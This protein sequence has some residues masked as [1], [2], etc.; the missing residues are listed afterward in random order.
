MTPNI[1]GIK[2]LPI[3]EAYKFGIE[4]N[5]KDEISIIQNMEINWGPDYRSTIRRGF[6]VALFIYK[7]IFEAFKEL[8][9][10][11][12]RT[13]SGEKRISKYL[14]IKKLVDI[15]TSASPEAIEQ[16]AK[17][18]PK[19]LLFEALGYLPNLLKK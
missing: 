16:A 19:R 9:W 4:N 3:N 18:V 10:P 1:N 17:E 11:Y 2:D 14:E 12:G 7:G 8:Y 13:K 5:L 15:T 6:I